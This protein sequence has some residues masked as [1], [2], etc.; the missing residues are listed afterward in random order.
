MEAKHFVKSVA[1][2][3]NTMTNIYNF[4]IVVRCVK[5]KTGIAAFNTTIKNVSSIFG[6]P[7]LIILKIESVFAHKFE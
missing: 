5:L 1:I 6:L 4:G 7:S 2:S 3:L